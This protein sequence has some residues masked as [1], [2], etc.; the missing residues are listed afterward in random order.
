M[1]L[2]LCRPLLLAGL[3]LLAGCADQPAAPVTPGAGPVRAAGEAAGRDRYIVVF[4]ANVGDVR[5]EAERL[6]RAGGGEV[7]FVYTPALRGF[8]ARLP[9][10]A[11]EALR[12]NPNVAYVEPDL[13][14][15][16]TDSQYLAPAN[17]ER[18]DHR[19]LSGQD[20]YW[21]YGADGSGANIYIID[22]GVSPPL[23]PEFSQGYGFSRV[24]SAHT[25]VPDGQGTT[26][27]NG[28]GTH[29]A[30]IAGGT[31]YGV[32]KGATLHAV[33]VFACSGPSY[34]SYLL[35]GIAWVAANHRKPAVA[36]LSVAALDMYQRE[37]TSQALDDAVTGLINSGVTAVASAGNENK[38]ACNV[39]PGRVGAA[40]TVGSINVWSSYGVAQDTRSSFSNFGSCLD[41]FAPG[42][43]I[44]AANN[45]CSVVVVCGEREESGTSMAA[46]HAAGVAAMY[47]SANPTAVP[48][49]VVSALVNNATSGVLKN[50]GTGSPNR[51]LY[52]AF[53][54]DAWR[55]RA[56]VQGPTYV[57][58]ATT[59]ATHTF[60]AAAT[61]GD[62]AYTY[63]W[64]VSWY[65]SGAR[66]GQVQT[67]GTGATQDIYVGS[68]DGEFT[69]RVRVRT[70]SRETSA[71]MNVAVW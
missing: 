57:D 53:V 48:A 6:A 30:G 49:T 24:V 21:G 9:A 4:R 17:L 64:E 39:S 26:D 13:Q 15:V 22:T 1:K 45:N 42:E 16:P 31:K 37:T 27:C 12:R 50:I 41:L 19:P 66:Q 60:T 40:L 54:S 32:A 43:R 33:R 70:P 65:G 10:A 67:L 25:P 38:N 63:Q 18:L 36:N 51:L 7:L 46:P 3:A 34:L 68:D 5:G 62:G 69:V 55:L 59:P 20:F 29:V 14:I 2:D 11:A 71:W 35:D 8:A 61:G 28:H 56:A 52:N 58:K 47:L 23:H 44:Y